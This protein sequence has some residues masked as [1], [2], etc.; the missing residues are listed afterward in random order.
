M[1]GVPGRRLMRWLWPLGGG[2]PVGVANTSANSASSTPRKSCSVHACNCGLEG[3]G[4]PC[5]QTWWSRRQKDMVRRPKSHIIGPK[6]A[7]H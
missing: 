1:G 5:Q 3:P 6:V 7:S 2:K 4:M